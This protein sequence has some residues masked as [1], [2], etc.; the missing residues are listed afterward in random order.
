MST[1]A[2]SEPLLTPAQVGA[3]FKVDP[4]TAT[5]W[6]KAG[7]LTSIRTPGGHYRFHESEVRALLGQCPQCRHITAHDQFG[8]MLD[9]CD[10]THPGE[11]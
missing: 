8:C 10:C 4:K 11:A 1:T 5:R 6:A 3:M 9:T 2:E 7:K